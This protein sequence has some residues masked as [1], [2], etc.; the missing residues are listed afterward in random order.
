LQRL[1]RRLGLSV[2]PVEL[3][4]FGPFLAWSERYGDLRPVER[5]LGQDHKVLERLGGLELGIGDTAYYLVERPRQPCGD[6]RRL[7]ELQVARQRC[8]GRGEDGEPSRD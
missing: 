6:F 2:E 3:K 8:M 7:A 1:V 4:R 5:R